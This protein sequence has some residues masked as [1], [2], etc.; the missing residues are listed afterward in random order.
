MIIVLFGI[1]II[2]MNLNMF[3]NK[4]MVPI[5]NLYSLIYMRKCW[6]KI[7]FQYDK[8]RKVINFNNPNFIIMIIY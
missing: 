3:I 8:Q 4:F 1:V 2:I 5:R 7:L 6:L